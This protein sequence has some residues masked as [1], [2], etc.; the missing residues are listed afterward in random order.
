MIILKCS[1]LRKNAFFDRKGICFLFQ[2]RN[3]R[4]FALEE[5]VKTCD[6]LDPRLQNMVEGIRKI[7]TPDKTVTNIPA[8]ERLLDENLGVLSHILGKVINPKDYKN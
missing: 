2:L 5:F 4:R 6:E 7:Q 1:K 8:M 3:I